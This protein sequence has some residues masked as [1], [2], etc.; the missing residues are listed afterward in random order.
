MAHEETPERKAAKLE[1]QRRNRDAKRR[2]ARMRD[3]PSIPGLLPIYDEHGVADFARVDVDAWDEF[4]DVRL[5]FA[6]HEYAT[7][8]KERKKVYLHRAILGLEAG[9]VR[10]CDHINRDTLDNR[11]ANL[12]MAT[13][14][15]NAHNRGGVYE[16]CWARQMRQ[17]AA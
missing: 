7:F 8:A 1:W 14:L 15:E 2:A 11:R 9:D 5:H 13:V 17:E 4:K 3:V 16:R 10:Q 12:R 6:G